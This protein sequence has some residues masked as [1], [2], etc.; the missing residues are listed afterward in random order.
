MD[1]NGFKW[2]GWDFISF[3]VALSGAEE[4]HQVHRCKAEGNQGEF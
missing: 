2:I 1:L 4:N 3:K